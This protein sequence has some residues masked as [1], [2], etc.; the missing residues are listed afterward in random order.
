MCRH[1]V[2]VKLLQDHGVT[3]LSRLVSRWPTQLTSFHPQKDGGVERLNRIL[4]DMLVGRRM[5]LSSSAPTETSSY[6]MA[7]TTSF[8][9]QKDGGVECL[10]RIL[11]DMLAGR[12]TTSSAPTETSSYHIQFAIVYHVSL[13]SQPRSHLSTC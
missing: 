11:T 9:P 5:T 2:P 10:N 6:H 12:R 8:H 7:N 1:R 3:F 4:T 13:Q